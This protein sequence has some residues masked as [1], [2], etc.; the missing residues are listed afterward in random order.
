MQKQTFLWILTQLNVMVILII[1]KSFLNPNVKPSSGAE[2]FW[3]I[4]ILAFL[5][6]LAAALWRERNK[7][8]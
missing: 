5:I 1:L 7:N 4:G 8:S 3:E 6:T 2:Y